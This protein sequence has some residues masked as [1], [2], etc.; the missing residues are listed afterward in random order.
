VEVTVTITAGAGKVANSYYSG[1]FDITLTSPSG[2]VSQLAVPHLCSADQFGACTSTYN[3]WVFGDAAHL[4]EAPNGTWTLKVSDGINGGTP[5]TLVSWGL[6]I[7]G[8]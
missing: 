3:A 6:K 4:G 7:Y 2:M 8:Y 1:D 5:G